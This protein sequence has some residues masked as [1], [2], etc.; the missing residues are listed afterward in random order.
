MIVIAPFMI[1][2]APDPATAR[3]T[4]NILEFV[5]IAHI[6]EPSSKTIRKERN[7]YYN[8]KYIKL[9]LQLEWYDEKNSP[10]GNE[11]CRF[12][13]KGAAENSWT[14]GM[15]CRTSRHLGLN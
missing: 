1:P 11:K 13:R 4:M 15:R 2:D 9:G 6:K 7:V 10:L 3:P 12:S 5:E 8:P 14:R